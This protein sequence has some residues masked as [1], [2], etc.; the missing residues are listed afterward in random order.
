MPM[1][2]RDIS[3]L[4][5]VISYCED[6]ERAVNRFGH[7]YEAFHADKDYR[8]CCA[9]CILQIGELGGH[10]SPEFR[11]AHGAW[12][13]TLGQHPRDAKRHGPRLWHHKCAD[14]LGDD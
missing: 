6:I 14:N 4:R 12:G 3:I 11:M 8:N 9:M 2:E 7:S 1:S 13:N 5:H 10:L